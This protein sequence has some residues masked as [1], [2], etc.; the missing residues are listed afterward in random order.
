MAT[1]IEKPSREPIQPDWD[2]I[3][4][5]QSPLVKEGRC[6]GKIGNVKKRGCD[7]TK[8]LRRT[9][10]G[11]YCIDCWRRLGKCVI[12]GNRGRRHYAKSYPVTCDR[13]KNDWEASDEKQLKQRSRDILYKNRTWDATVG[14]RKIK[15]GEK[16]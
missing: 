7:I 11:V 10:E 6:A 1:M 5:A 8:Q 4:W 9:R 13:H 3:H 2:L 14:D 12:C 15:E 16:A